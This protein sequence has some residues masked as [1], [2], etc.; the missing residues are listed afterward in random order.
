MSLHTNSLKNEISYLGN[1]SASKR[2]VTKILAKSH[3]FT[4]SIQNTSDEAQSNNLNKNISS[5]IIRKKKWEGK[6]EDM[7]SY[8]KEF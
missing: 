7:N 8:F 4:K 6:G 5:L 3:I 2:S 1:K